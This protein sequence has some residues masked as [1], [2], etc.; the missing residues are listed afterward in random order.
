MMLSDAIKGEV[1]LDL[2]HERQ[3][4]DQ[5]WG[6]QR[7]PYPVWLMILTEEV[8]EV[9]EAM[10]KEYGWGKASDADDLYKELIHVAAVALAIAEQ[11]KEEREQDANI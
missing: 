3:R 1:R 2:E 7:H 6:V 10:Q 11:V 5:K 8:G 9:A 4:Q